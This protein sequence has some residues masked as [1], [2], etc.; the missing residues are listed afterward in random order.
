MFK[1]S[2]AEYNSELEQPSF[3]AGYKKNQYQFMHVILEDVIVFAALLFSLR[4]H[5]SYPR[6]DHSWIWNIEGVNGGVK[7]SNYGG[8]KLT[9]YFKSFPLA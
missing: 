6:P 5:G 1:H 4:N 7:L 9:T 2:D 8:I 3:L